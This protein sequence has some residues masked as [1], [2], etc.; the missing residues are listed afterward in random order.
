MITTFKQCEHDL[1]GSP[2][3][4]VQLAQKESARILVV[5]DSHGQHALLKNI[6]EHMGASCD[7]FVFCGDGIGD[8][9]SC[10]DCAY[11]DSV[12]AQC[13]P[14]VAAFVKGNG[15]ADR[16]P[17]VFNPSKNEKAHK[18]AAYYEL[19]VPRSQLL[20]AAHRTIF[21]AHGHEFGAYCGTDA[22]AEAAKKAGACVV[23]YGHTHIA[24]ETQA[25]VYLANPGSITYPRAGTPPSFAILELGQNFINAIFYKIETQLRGV[26]FTPF[27]PKKTSLWH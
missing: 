9:V 25:G 4:I 13:V 12:F 26:R 5:S 2:R 18:R 3:E 10:F 16:F 15:D 22:L 7:A 17:A 6:L 27:A 14:P 24:A 21:I 1:L 11:D 8:V 19:A 20:T 23:L